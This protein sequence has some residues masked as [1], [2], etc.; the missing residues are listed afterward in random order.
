MADLRWWR[1]ESPVGDLVVV[2]G[3]SGLRQLVVG[4]A[5]DVDM[6]DGVTYPE[7]DDE[8]ATELDEYFAGHRRVFTMPIDL[9]SVEAPFRR[10]VLETLYREVGFGE[11]ITYGELAAL[12]GRPRAARAV[13]SAM[14]TNPIPIV[15]PCH[16]VLA[17]G[18]HLGGYGGALCMKRGL[19]GLEGV[20]IEG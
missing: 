9:S 17:A 14:A 7:R 4:G 2:M 12:A 18:G 3:D 16:R 6:I 20:C 11:T 13:G 5:V 1:H 15:V 10:T 19:L 8:V